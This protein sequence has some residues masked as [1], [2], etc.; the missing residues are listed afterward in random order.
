MKLGYH[1]YLLHRLERDYPREIVNEIKLDKDPID[2][3]IELFESFI[4]RANEEKKA[5]A[6]LE[7]Q[8]E[9]N[10]K[11]KNAARKKRTSEKA[12]QVRAEKRAE[13]QAAAA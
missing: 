1:S 5:V 3:F 11:E 4:E 10:K 12:K 9:D 7:K 6:E 2:S 8:I 13:K